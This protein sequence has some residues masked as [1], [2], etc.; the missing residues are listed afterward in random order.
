MAMRWLALAV[1]ALVSSGCSGIRYYAHVAHGQVALLAKRE[2]IAAIVEDPAR[3]PAL[4]QRLAQAL[5]ARGFASDH[6]GLPHNRSYESHVELGRPYVSW[7]VLA[8]AEFSIEPVLHCFPFA[9]CVAYQGWFDEAHAQRQAAALMERGMD[10]S[11]QGAIAYSTLG[12]FADPIL[13]SMLR[14]SDDQLDGTIFHELAHQK[15]YVK[16]DT[17]FNESWAS[18]VERQGLREWHAARGLPPPDTHADARAEAFSR[19]VLDLRE[20]LKSLYASGLPAAEM[21]ARKQAGFDAFRA[22]HARMRET[23][24]KDDARYDRWVAGPLNN[25]SLLSFGLYDR[26]VGAFARMFAAADGSWPV[27]HARVAALAALPRDERDAQLALL[28]PESPDNADPPS[29]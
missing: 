12:W 15:L 3:D 19:Q 28:A 1:G 8:T 4:R 14:W 24:W 29:H 20:R 16:D 13:S 5:A 25:A 7:N 27:F 17:A 6:L 22:W 9:G 26:W 11:V 2:R 18:F 23:E 10:T 21:R